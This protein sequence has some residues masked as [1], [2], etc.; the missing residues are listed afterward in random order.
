M[1]TRNRNVLLVIACDKYFQVAFTFGEK[2]SEMIFNS[3]LPDSLKKDV[4]EAKKY[5]ECRTIQIDVKTEDD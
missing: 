2:A 4:F 5:T 1:F 3:G